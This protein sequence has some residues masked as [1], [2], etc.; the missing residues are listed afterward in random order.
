M[1][2]LKRRSLRL[3]KLSKLSEMAELLSFREN[4]PGR[5]GMCIREEMT[6]LNQAKFLVFMAHLDGNGLEKADQSK[7]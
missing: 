6:S 7:D 3:F 1:W 4:T 5:T 2:H